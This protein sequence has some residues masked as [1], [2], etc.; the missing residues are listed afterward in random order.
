MNSPNISHPPSQK[1]GRWFNA[2]GLT[3]V[4]VIVAALI[5]IGVR[6]TL[7]YEGRLA[8]RD[9][10]RDA[11][12]RVAMLAARTVGDDIAACT[13][14]LDALGAAGHGDPSAQLSNC[15]AQFGDP[16]NATSQ[17]YVQAVIMSE[18]GEVV[19]EALPSTGCIDLRFA[20]RIVNAHRQS[21]ND[22]LSISTSAALC[23]A[24]AGPGLLMTHTIRRDGGEFAGVSIVTIDARYFSRQF[25]GLAPGE[26]GIVSLMR[27]DG[28]V[29]ITSTAAGTTVAS[30]V[31][32]VAV[33]A[34]PSDASVTGADGEF[35][36][37]RQ[38]LAG[39]PMLI[40]IRAPRSEIYASWRE[41]ALW[42]GGLTAALGVACLILSVLL[43][44]QRQRRYVA[45]A[46]LHRMASTDPLT[47]LANRRTLD[48]TYDREW[49]RSLREHAP[50]ALLFIDIDHFKT[51]ND[52]YGH[53]AGDDTL[54]AVS[55]AIGRTIRR[56]G[57]FA[58]RYGGEEFMVVLPNTDANGARDVAE[59]VRTAVRSL[60]IAHEGTPQG[61]VTISIGVAATGVLPTGTPE[62]LLQAADEALYAA[63][64][65]GRDRV[66]IH[67]TSGGA[68]CPVI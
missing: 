49:R 66:C 32:L 39:L 17:T 2:L 44:K 65:G 12:L 22:A 55:H 51:F 15:M 24:S 1:A 16:A 56:P 40:E 57:D 38:P 9:D 41:R 58:G 68:P 13:R 14:A 19:Y 31:P 11:N 36:Y 45:E 28:T 48:E 47:G 64:S 63:K 54:V 43:R 34:R 62:A 3:V 29:L 27:N 42:V 6:A 20:Q 18:A 50:L 26:K 33:T 30:A 25:A 7:L 10:A 8:V 35:L 53:P 21:N 61:H 23:P 59:R 4:V 67:A 37:V 46:E 52:Q 5:V 60:A